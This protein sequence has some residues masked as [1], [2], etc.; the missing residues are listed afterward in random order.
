MDIY[1]L[2]SNELK[3]IFELAKKG[4]VEKDRFFKYL[5]DK[6]SYIQEEAANYLWKIGVKWTIAPVG[7]LLSI[8]YEEIDHG[9]IITH[10][11]NFFSPQVVSWLSLGLKDENWDTRVR[12]RLFILDIVGKKAYDYLYVFKSDKSYIFIPKK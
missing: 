10:L 4:H 1:Q 9:S 2:K 6:D 12:I 3:F 5:K 7:H 8:S 11:R